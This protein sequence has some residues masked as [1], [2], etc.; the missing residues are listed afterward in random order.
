MESLNQVISAKYAR[1]I[2]AGIVKQSLN[3]VATDGAVDSKVGE[4]VSTEGSSGQAS[5]RKRRKT[6]NPV[7]SE[8]KVRLINYA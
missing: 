3:P 4:A 6:E 8:D 1:P 2:P 7:T 5:A